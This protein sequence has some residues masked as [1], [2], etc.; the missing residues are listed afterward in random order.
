MRFWFA[1][2]MLF[3]VSGAASA[4]D[5]GLLASEFAK[6]HDD[7]GKRCGNF[8]ATAIAGCAYTLVTDQPLHVTFGT[9]A[10]QNGVG[11]GPALVG[12]VNPSETWRVNW[13]GDGVV[14]AGGAWRA[15]AYVN[16]VHTQVTRPVMVSGEQPLP[17]A[18]PD[19]YPV[20]SLYVQSIKLPSLNYYA[21]DASS[22][23]WAM[24]QT[25]FGA[26]GLMPFGPGAAGLAVNFGATARFLEIGGK[27]NGHRTVGQFT[28]GLRVVPTFSAHVLPNYRFD[29][30]EFLSS[31]A[32][33][34]RW[35]ADLPHEFPFYQI[36]RGRAEGNTPNH[37]AAPGADHGCPAPSRG[38]YGAVSVRVKAIGSLGDAVPFYLQPTLG[39]ADIN[40]NLALSGL[41]DYR[42][43]GPSL[44]LLQATIEHSLVTIPLGRGFALPLGGLARAEA[45]RTADR[46]GDVFSSLRGS[47]EAGLTIRAGGFPEVFLLC[48]RAG[49]DHRVS[50]LINPALLGASRPS[51]F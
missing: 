28:G 10:P 21:P 7:V 17:P 50:A 1:V 15:G 43:R 33:F 32:T 51:L 34:T 14:A 39:G 23:S 18:T 3:A 8:S 16:F 30:D 44:L 46:F 40:G 5:Q 47:Y 13:S 48:A 24:R 25:Q 22:A 42:F 2:V 45:G 20:Y 36:N 9:I 27:T 41:P 29:V 6:E 35:T 38:R 37:C 12:E 49:G 26:S 4:Q 31:G 11:F 19:V